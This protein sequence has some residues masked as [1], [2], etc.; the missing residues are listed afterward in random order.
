M[1]I[2]RDGL[3]L[4][5]WNHMHVFERCDYMLQRPGVGYGIAMEKVFRL[6]AELQTLALKAH[7]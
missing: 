4:C 5:M 6:L 7:V 1:N 3:A 2:Q